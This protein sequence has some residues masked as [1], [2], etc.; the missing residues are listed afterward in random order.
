[1]LKFDGTTGFWPECFAAE[2]G[3]WEA[4]LAAHLKGESRANDTPCVKNV[5]Q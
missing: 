1:M 5:V 4:F 3:D 2:F